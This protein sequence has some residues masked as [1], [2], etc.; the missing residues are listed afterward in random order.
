MTVDLLRQLRKVEWEEDSMEQLE[1]GRHID[2]SR[3]LRK[4]MFEGESEHGTQKEAVPARNQRGAAR[5][6][7]PMHTALGE[8]NETATTVGQACG[9]PGRGPSQE[10]R[11]PMI[12][13][14]GVECRGQG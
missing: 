13:A 3:S 6:S 5:D 11:D 10:R 1:M 4:S 14:G 12:Q 8:H 7:V 2:E 9:P